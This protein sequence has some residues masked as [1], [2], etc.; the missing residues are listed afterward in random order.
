MSHFL[1]TADSTMA[2]VETSKF[3]DELRQDILHEKLKPRTRKFKYGRHLDVTG[4]ETDNEDAAADSA[5]W[6][7]L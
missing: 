3:K 7:L 6:E 5:W 1:E 4:N 2:G